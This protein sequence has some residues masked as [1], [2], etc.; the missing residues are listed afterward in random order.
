[1]K[2]TI[3]GETCN[4]PGLQVGVLTYA[5]MYTNL[6]ASE[7]A[8][9]CACV[10]ACNPTS[11]S[12]ICIFYRGAIVSVLRYL[13]VDLI[14][15]VTGEKRSARQQMRGGNHRRPD[16]HRLKETDI[17]TANNI[18]HFNIASFLDTCHLL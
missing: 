10:G 4:I 7:C 14:S 2:S 15:M 17:E 18:V 6:R 13:H 1:M 8:R 12:V 11:G 16:T 3:N 5:R 9:L